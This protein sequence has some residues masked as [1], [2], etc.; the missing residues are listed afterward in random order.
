MVYISSTTIAKSLKLHQIQVRKDLA[1]VSNTPG[2]PRIGF[3]ILPSIGIE[4]IETF[5]GYNYMDEVGIVGVGRLEKTL[6]SYNGFKNYGLKIIAGFHINEEIVEIKVNGKS[7]LPLSK[8]AQIVK[9]L[10]VSISIITVPKESAQE[11]CNLMVN[12]DIKAIWNFAPI[13]I[14][15]PDGAIIRNENL[16]ASLANLFFP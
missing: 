15:I 6:L 7:V 13:Y 14:E 4:D 8:L 10:N 1:Y 16:A 9:K 5:W 2:K 3:E 11:I 12:S